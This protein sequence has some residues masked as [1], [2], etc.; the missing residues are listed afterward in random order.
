MERD[1]MVFYRSFAESIKELEP[2]DQLKALWAII[3][4]GIDGI[5]PEEKGAH[6]AIFK[7]AKPQ[8]DANNQRYVN[9]KKKKTKTEPNSNQ[10]D[11]ETE[12]NNDQEVTKPLTKEK[13]KEKVKVKD[14]ATQYTR[15]KKKPYSGTAREQDFDEMTKRLL[16]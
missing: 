4:Y 1:G 9:S 5:E 11:T 3:E 10:T 15:T 6:K 12:S 7:M 8:I 2:E 16:V 13:V 14:I